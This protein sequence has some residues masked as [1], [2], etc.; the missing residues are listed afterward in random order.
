M[1]GYNDRSFGRELLEKKR[2]HRYTKV[3]VFFNPS[4]CVSVGTDVYTQKRCF[5]LYK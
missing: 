1:C 5:E 3:I 4:A 2:V